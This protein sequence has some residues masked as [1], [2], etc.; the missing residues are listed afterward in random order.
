MYYDILQGLIKEYKGDRSEAY[1]E[2]NDLIFDIERN[3]KQV[4]KDF[5]QLIQNDLTENNLCPVCRLG[6]STRQEVAN[7]LE[8][9]G[10]TV[11]ENEYQF[12]RYCENCGWT[13]EKSE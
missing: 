3:P 9:Q 2:L 13:N 1:D 7:M 4:V 5:K 12:T 11:D 6:L 8:Y 10:N